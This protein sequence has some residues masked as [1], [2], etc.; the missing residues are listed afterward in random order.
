MANMS[1]CMF[2]NTARDLEDCVF[3]ME[4][5]DSLGDLD[6][7]PYEKAAFARMWDI[8]RRFLAEHARLLNTEEVADACE[9]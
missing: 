7:N 5:A 2:E 4:E 3:N 1:Y 9:D 6:M 8:A